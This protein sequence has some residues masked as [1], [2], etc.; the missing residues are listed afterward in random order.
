MDSHLFAR[1][2]G[3]IG[4]EAIQRAEIS[5]RLHAIQSAANVEFDGGASQR[6]TN[7]GN[8]HNGSQGRTGDEIRAHRAGVNCIAM[9]RFEGR[10]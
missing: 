6:T 1:A 9:D 3:S 7:D 4:P 2:L 10:Q 8:Q 5:R